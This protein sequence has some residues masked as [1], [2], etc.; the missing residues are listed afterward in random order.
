MLCFF[1]HFIFF[2]LIFTLPLG[3][4]TCVRR[5]LVFDYP[6]DLQP[7]LLRCL[8]GFLLPLSEL[9]APWYELALQLP[10]SS[11]VLTNQRAYF[12]CAS[13]A[14]ADVRVRVRRRIVSV[15]RER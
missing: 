9:S 15:H 2:S 5:C 4:T 6:G 12:C 3:G 14:E 13:F 10:L 1:L 8:S 7:L 11:Q